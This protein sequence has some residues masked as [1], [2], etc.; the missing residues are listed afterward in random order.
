MGLFPVVVH[1]AGPQ[2]NKLLED[3]GV[4]PEFEEGIRI[5][6]GKT[7]GVAR[8]LFLEENL[9][10]VDELEAIGPRARPITSGVF[11]ADYLDKD[12]YKFVGKISS[13]NKAPIEAAIRDG[14]I[15]ILTSMAESSEG[16]ILNVNA[17]VAAGELARALQPL[18]IVYLS[19]KGGLFNG[20]TNERISAINLDEE[21]D[22]LMKHWWVRHGTRLKIKEM[23]QLLDDLP[24]SS[25]VAI[26]HPAHLEKELFTDTGA[27]TLIRRGNKLNTASSVDDFG[28]LAK[29][30]ETLVRDRDGL[31]A[32][33]V[34]DRYIESLRTRPFTAYF[35][36]QQEGLGIVLPPSNS[37]S[38]AH[39]ATFTVTKNGWLTNIA[40]NIFQN[41]QKE[42]PRLLWTVRQDDENL[43]WFFDRAD[44]SVSKDGEVLFWYGVESADEVRELMVEFTQHGRDMFGDI[45]LESQLQRAA[46][47][48]TRL[49]ESV[50]GQGQQT[51]AYSTSTRPLQGLSRR[52]TARVTAPG[53][54]SRRD[55]ATTTNPNPPLG[56]HNSSNTTP[57]R[58]A[59][60]GARGYTGKALV[61]L[62]N[63]HPYLDLRHVSSRELAGQKLQSY[64]KREIVHENL[65][66]DDVRS[67]AEKGSVDVWVM[68][69]P[70]GVCKPF[71]DA[72]NE[73]SKGKEQV[74]V[75]LSADYRFDSSWTY[76]LP[77][78]V[79]RSKIAKAKRISNP[80]CYATAAQVGIAPM[81]QHLGGQPVVFGVSGYSGAGTKP[82]PKNDVNNLR[83]NIIAY[84][85]T[86]HIHEREIS[87]QLGTDVAFV[88]HVA[89]WFQ[90]IHVSS[91]CPL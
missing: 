84:S 74:I 26:I 11:K 7:L 59:L 87:A 50:T 55:Y 13:V 70:N 2:L 58:V 35:D 36:E 3:A 20:D 89:V 51:R 69:L 1:G 27:G 63:K 86:D 80:G 52:P 24:R 10:L 5:T 38:L 15:P 56:R 28:D 48:A 8:K 83:D 19:E 49:R 40:D 72:I 46:K 12:K 76:G 25:S 18:K 82:S 53:I 77:E 41:L 30:K 42:H 71:V 6:D 9:K 73:T 57:S 45:N 31:D 23:K 4:Q 43:T 79:A 66:P 88:P 90:G 17:D 60:V 85:L 61:E 65:T 62:L 67:M 81:L 54:S 32:E 91:R 39:L 33:A 22:E 75:D 16:Q 34:V 21:Y 29:L 44:G 64:D 37:T 14:C 78:L 47:A 68:A